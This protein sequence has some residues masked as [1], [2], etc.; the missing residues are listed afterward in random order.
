MIKLIKLAN[1]I[2]YRT[3]KMSHLSKA[4]HL[5]SS[6][7][8]I[9]I[10]VAI[11]FSNVFKFNIKNNLKGDKFILSKGHAAAAFYS[12]LAEKK[13]FSIKQL[14]KYG[15]NNSIYEEH[16]N[17]KINGVICST[18][19]L[20]HGLS[21]GVG[22]SLA[23]KLENKKYKNIILLSDGECNEGSVWEA[24]AFASAQ[25]L[26][27][28]IVIVDSNKWQA[29]G[30][31][32]DITGGELQKKWKAFGWKTYNINGNNIIELIKYLK[33]SKN[34][35]NKKPIAIIANTIKGKGISFMEDDNNWHYR[36][37]NKEE[38]KNIK[39]ILNQ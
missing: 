23:E 38:L 4:A 13:Y 3:C 21:F 14:S 15:K 6:L 1:K 29:T 17:S 26:S 2:R 9:D 24:A 34:S 27:N 8:C 20:G 33:L 11:F 7:S 35:N 5:G 30:R 39:I 12:I 19:S 16:P 10:L 22:I 31:T 32:S 37:P 25:K 36:I 28:I 18:G